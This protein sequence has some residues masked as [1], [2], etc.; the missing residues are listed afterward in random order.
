MRTLA[1][2]VLALAVQRVHPESVAIR[3]QLRK[4]PSFL[5]DDFVGG[6]V[7]L[8]QRQVVIFT[9]FLQL[10]QFVQAAMQGALGGDHHLLHAAANGEKGNAPVERLA[11]QRQA[12][13]V[14]ARSASGSSPF[15]P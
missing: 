5:N 12:Q 11:D 15:S 14:S 7:L 3:Y 6:G 2:V 9:V 4:Q 10:G 13:R 1:P 8:F